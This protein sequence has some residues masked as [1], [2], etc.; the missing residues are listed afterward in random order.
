MS[1]QQRSEGGQR[2]TQSVERRTRSLSVS[3]VGGDGGFIENDK[4]REAARRA[5]SGAG[6]AE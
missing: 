4:R 6:D 3:P 5:R 1:K 2:S